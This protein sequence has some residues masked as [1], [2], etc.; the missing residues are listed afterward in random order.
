MRSM[1][2]CSSQ[3]WCAEPITTMGGPKVKVTMDITCL[4]LAFRIHAVSTIP[5]KRFSLKF[6]QLFT[7]VK[8]CV[9][10]LMHNAT[11]ET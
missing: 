4:S 3:R 8:Q 1:S 5:L 11:L 9:D 2:P 7:S 6:G 10:S